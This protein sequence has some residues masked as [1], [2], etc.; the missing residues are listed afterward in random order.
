MEKFT[1]REGLVLAMGLGLAACSSTGPLSSASAP[2]SAPTPTSLNAIA[3]GKGL[4]LGSTLGAGSA[5]SGSFRNPQY[6]ALL[7]ADCGILVPE[8]EL[9]WQAI[10]PTASTFEFARFDEQLAFAET[11][12]LAMRG[13]TLLWHRPEW[14]PGWLESHDFGASPSKAAEAM[15]RAHIETVC[16]RYKSRV[17]SYDVVNEAV[18]PETAQLAE[19]ALS[20]AFGGAQS[21][22]DLSFHLAREHAPGAQLVYNDYMSWEPGNETHRKGVLALLEGFRARGVPVDALG[23]QSHIRIDSYDAATRTAPRQERE[24]RAFLDAVVAMGYALVIT[25]FDVNDQALPAD[26]PARD[27]GVADYAKAY[28]DLMLSYPQM[29]DVML[30]GMCDRYSWLQNFKPL[31]QDGAAK[32]PCPYDQDFKAKPLHA[33]IAAALSRAPLRG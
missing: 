22:I 18:I 28:L 21:L 25:E 32:R 14:M 10:R 16:L 23:I 5:T 2:V 29:K 24:W 1:R 15:L 27:Q 7:K 26:I 19:T 11:N 20:K 4:R 3:R 12:G 31:R 13:H 30:W 8:N 33:A 9:K 6:A 17:I